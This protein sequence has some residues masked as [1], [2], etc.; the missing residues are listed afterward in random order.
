MLE[1]PNIR[2]LGIIHAGELYGWPVLVDFMFDGAGRIMAIRPR[3][4]PPAALPANGAIRFR[5]ASW[6]MM[7]GLA[8]GAVALSERLHSADAGE[9]AIIQAAADL[10][11]KA[12]GIILEA[13]AMLQARLAREAR[14]A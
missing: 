2:Q 4:L 9:A 11:L 6:S 10:E 8:G 7:L 13:Q 12:L 3:M 14:A 1:A 5:L